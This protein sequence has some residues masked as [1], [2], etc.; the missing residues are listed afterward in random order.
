VI[1]FRAIQSHYGVTGDKAVRILVIAIVLFYVVPL[2]LIV[3]AAVAI[4]I[5]AIVLNYF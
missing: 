2:V 3:L 4:V 5:A 1:A